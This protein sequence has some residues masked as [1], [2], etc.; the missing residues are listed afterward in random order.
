MKKY[1]I[2]TAILVFI[3]AGLFTYFIYDSKDFDYS[4]LDGRVLREEYEDKD[5]PESVEEVTEPKRVFNYDG[6]KI[7]IFGA[8]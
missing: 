5:L 6:E 3:F 4:N 1:I 2:F 8:D 7:E